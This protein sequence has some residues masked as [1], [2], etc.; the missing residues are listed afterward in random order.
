M[1]YILTEEEYT[2]L[3]KKPKKIINSSLNE[4]IKD[5]IKAANIERSIG[6]FNETLNISV[7]IRDIAPNLLQFIKSI[8]GI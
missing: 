3:N 1:Q 2:K 5:C 4:E 8:K 6:A 7:S